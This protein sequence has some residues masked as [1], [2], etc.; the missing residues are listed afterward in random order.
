M[1]A[2]NIIGWLI[3]ALP[4]VAWFIFIAKTQSLKDAI[5]CLLI[6]IGLTSIVCLGAYLSAI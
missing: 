2:V 6:V 4:F 3:L 1:S 5:Y